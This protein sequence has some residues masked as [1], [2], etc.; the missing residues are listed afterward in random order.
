MRKCQGV[1]IK[2]GITTLIIAR[3]LLASFTNIEFS[4]FILVIFLKYT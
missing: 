2:E 3:D 1:G 4:A